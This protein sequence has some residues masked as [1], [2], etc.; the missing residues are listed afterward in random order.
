L[1]EGGGESGAIGELVEFGVV[2][3]VE[4]D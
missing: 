2:E 1:E 3:V 4:E